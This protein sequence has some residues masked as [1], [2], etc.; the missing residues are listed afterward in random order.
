MSK[1]LEEVWLNIPGYEGLYQVSNYGKIRSLDRHVKDSNN[2]RRR[3]L[4]GKLLK[5]GI[6][7]KYQHVTLSISGKQ[8]GYT[9]HSL[10]LLTFKG[11]CPEGKETAHN[12][13]IRDDNRLVNLRYA[14]PV[15]NY[16]DRVLHNTDNRGE[17]HGRTCLTE[18]KVREIRNLSK[19]FSG[20]ELARKYSVSVSAI[21]NILSR[22]SWV[23]I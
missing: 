3:F 5:F 18:N 22:K 1:E 15:E 13:G 23:H 6:T 21:S 12:N 19:Y 4:K 16:Q 10:V 2:E 14:T 9:V 8:T 11:E 17:R 7:D 20:K